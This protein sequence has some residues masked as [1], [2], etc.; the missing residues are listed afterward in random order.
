MVCWISCGPHLYII[1]PQDI[2]FLAHSPLE[3]QTSSVV[4]CCII[5]AD[6]VYV[7]ISRQN[8]QQCFDTKHLSVSY[9]PLM[10]NTY[11]SS[12]TT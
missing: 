4:L 11:M 8:S 3:A 10:V 5:M 12:D 9:L 2:R 6:S 7:N 1:W